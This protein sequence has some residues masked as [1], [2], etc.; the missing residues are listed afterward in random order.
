MR[1]VPKEPE[2]T[3]SDTADGTE[4]ANS[5]I[6]KRVGPLFLAYTVGR[7]G[8][9]AILVLAFYLFGFQGFPGLITAALISVP[10]SYLAFRGWRMEL[11]NRIAASRAAKINFKN[12]FRSAGEES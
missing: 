2:P 3:Q 12:Q 10:L 5:P 9:F 4:S 6:Q 11:A 8:V 7:F 1:N